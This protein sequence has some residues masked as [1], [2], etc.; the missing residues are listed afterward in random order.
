MNIIFAVDYLYT[1]ECFAEMKKFYLKI[2]S[3]KLINIKYKHL[4][5]KLY[6]HVRKIFHVNI[7]DTDF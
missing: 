6:F 3:K 4:T 2:Y 7:C 5:S 1:S